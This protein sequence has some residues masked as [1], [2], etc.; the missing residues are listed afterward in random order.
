MGTSWKSFWNGVGDWFNNVGN[1][2]ENAMSSAWNWTTN[3]ALPAIGGISGWAAF[4]G[5]AGMSLLSDRVNGVKAS[6]TTLLKALAAGATAGLF[7]GFS[8][9]ASSYML[10]GS[11]GIVEKFFVSYV[12][13]VIF[14]GHN[15]VTDTIVNQIV[16]W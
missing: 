3:I 12:C 14:S 5:A 7:A 15:F 2:I 13:A 1:T 11:K 9:G 10:N 6:G 8:N 16:G 4:F